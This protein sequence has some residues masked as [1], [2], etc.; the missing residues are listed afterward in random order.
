[1]GHLRRQFREGLAVIQAAQQG[2][3]ALRRG[4]QNGHVPAEIAE[5]AQQR[6]HI[7][8]APVQLVQQRQSVAP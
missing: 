2:G 5:L 3:A 6:A 1:M 4:G 8:T 7:L